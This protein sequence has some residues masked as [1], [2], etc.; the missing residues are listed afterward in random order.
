M[1][2]KRNGFLQE[3]EIVLL[4]Y[5]WFVGKYVKGVLKK[6]VRK[7]ETQVNLREKKEL[8][9]LDLLKLQ[10]TSISSS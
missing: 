9:Y 4:C 8:L 2:P 5:C 3:V 6:Y 7:K 1:K 10:T